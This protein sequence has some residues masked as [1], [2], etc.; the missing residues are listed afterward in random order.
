LSTFETYMAEMA[1]H[2]LLSEEQEVALAEEY[3]QGRAAEKQLAEALVYDP[4]IKRA[5]EAAVVRGQEARKR[6]IQCNLRLVVSQAKRY[7]GRG[8]SFED[9]VQ[10]GN[11]GLIEAV[12]RFDP[13]RGVR[14]STYA[15]WWIRQGI[16]RAIANQARTVRLPAHV[17]E[18]LSRLWRTRER[19]A[20][21]LHRRPTDQELAEQMGVSPREVRRLIR[22]ERDVLS[23]NTPVGED[24]D[25]E[26]GDFVPDQD[27]PTME[28]TFAHHELQE[29]V[30]DIMAARLPPR[31]H[32]VLRLRFGLDGGQTRTLAQVAE[33]LGITRERVRQI[34]AR[35]LRRL[36][37]ASARRRDLREAWV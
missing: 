23:L 19:L 9:L 31:E 5:L 30:Q 32:K 3:V 6:M 29:K 14:F 36:R 13:Q 34:E 33:V 15:V 4:E 7:S 24:G 21:Q 35:A 10:E 8:L 26:L 22:S 28:E 16:L 25:S 2:S 37:Y 20:S 17:S 18:K 11:I 27:T 1:R 12:E